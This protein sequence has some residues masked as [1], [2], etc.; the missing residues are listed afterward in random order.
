MTPTILVPVDLSPVSPQLVA[1]AAMLARDL[2]ASLLLLHVQQSYVGVLGS[3]LYDPVLICEN[4]ELLKLLE[5]LKPEDPSII[6]EHRLILGLP[7]ATILRVAEEEQ[8]RLI[9]MGSHGRTGVSR[10]LLGSVAET[11]LRHASCPVMIFK[12]PAPSQSPS[13]CV[14]NNSAVLATGSDSGELGSTRVA[15]RP[16][17]S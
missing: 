13:I 11:V 16:E 1:W 14:T 5:A 9:V 15:K 4:P 2:A 17:A 6:C 3:E 10:M 7:A 12:Q 8:V